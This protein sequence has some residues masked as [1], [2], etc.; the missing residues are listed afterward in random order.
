ME[1]EME[2]GVERDRKAAHSRSEGG[3]ARGGAPLGSLGLSG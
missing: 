3:R 2:A 1:R